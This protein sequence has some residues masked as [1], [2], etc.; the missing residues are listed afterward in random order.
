MTTF[1]LVH[2]AWGGSW[3]W[4]DFANL[5]RA[6]GHEV[7]TPSLTG[8][9]E[10]VHLGGPQVN[11][12]THVTDVENVFRYEDLADVTLVGHSYG[13]MVITGVVDRIPD[14]ISHLVYVDAFLPRDGESCFDLGGAGGRERANIEDGWKVLPGTLA[15]PPATPEA[16]ERLRKLSPQPLGTFDEKVRLSVPLEERAFSLAYVKATA[17][18]PMDTSAF[19]QAA[20]RT[21][22][23]PRWRY[24]E[25]PCGHG[26]QRE[27][28]H[29][30]KAILDE[31]IS[32]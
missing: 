16:A 23:D 6:D 7:Y 14:L 19:W 26:I 32:G 25:L 9:G 4:R 3:G 20:A 2:G 29:E 1:V 8:Q 11:L 28:P 15:P 22:A 10:R 5:L 17:G 27:M 30:L 31:V 24:Y 18:P 13:G 12:S 21:K